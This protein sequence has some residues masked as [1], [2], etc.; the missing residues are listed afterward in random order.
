M[1]QPHLKHTVR[2]SNFY[3]RQAG[4]FILL[5]LSCKISFGQNYSWMKGSTT[6]DQ[7]GIYGTL[8]VASPANTPG[9]REVAA[10]WKDAAGN[11]W[12][13][14]G[15]GTDITGNQSFLSD[16]W[17][18]TPST[19]QW[20][21]INGD[22]ISDQDGVYGTQGVAAPANKPGARECAVTWADASGNL[23]L[24]GG[25]SYG[26]NGMFGEINDLWKYT[27]STNQWT[28]VNGSNAVMQNSVYGTL[29]VAA[30]ANVPGARGFSSSWM[31]ASGNLWLFG[32]EGY[33]GASNYG[34]LND[35][36]KYDIAANQWT[37][38][39]GNNS[40]N[41]NG[42]YGTIGV[43]AATNIPGGR[44]LS[45]HW[46]DASGNFWLC[47]GSAFDATG[48]SDDIINDLWKYS[49]STNQWTWVKGS[50]ST[51][52]A[53]TYGTQGVSA[54]ANVPGARLG[55]ASWVDNAGN[56]FLFGGYGTDATAAQDLLN[57]IWNYNPSTNQWTWVKGS[58]LNGQA[59][60]YG[61]QGI[62]AAGN[63][64][65]GRAGASSWYDASGN[66][67][68]FGGSGYS[69]NAQG[70]DLNDLWKLD[71]CTSP[72][73]TI[74][75]S[76]SAF[77][78][79]GTT[80]LTASGA[81]TYT[82][83]NNQTGSVS[84]V[85]PTVT[86]VLTLT[87]FP[88]STAGCTGSQTVSVNVFALPTVTAATS[89]S[90]SCKGESVTVSS[91]GAVTYSWAT[92]ANTTSAIVVS[93]TIT[94]TYSVRGT[95]AN[96]C[97]DFATITQTVIICTGIAEQDISE[98]IYKVY[99]NPANGAFTIVSSEFGTDIIFVLVNMIGQKVVEERLSAEQTKIQ[100][101]LPQ[102][103]YQYTI[104][105]H[106]KKISTGKLIIE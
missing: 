73:V 10:S 63:N 28:W 66:L 85:T 106:D 65:G 54:S 105:K 38:V 67:W 9:A 17:K 75:S 43:A 56:F 34:G 72:T 55:S 93:P 98:S 42:T 7:P 41:N 80:T 99:P 86:G 14:G 100:A 90:V 89:R 8:G 16:L 102:G 82:W 4:I 47:G 49:L 94:T 68:L 45:A 3:V 61:T 39:S 15:Y 30:A 48:S 40:I 53:G 27:I 88:T 60:V 51:G 101:P 6:A 26:A 1:K 5:F 2:K 71:N 46:A 12:L 23:W 103:V 76:G 74:T 52:Q 79:G 57:D 22:N 32:G 84:V 24:F 13:F 19:N 104:T 33:D 83:S 37:W 70:G 31:D 97:S 59:G 95:D 77:C 36:W 96:G 91:G 62:S 20:T 64:P 35:L 21:W 25:V 87:C 50:N 78:F 18:Y 81:A 69:G 58:N 44:Y 11:F 29:G 92:P